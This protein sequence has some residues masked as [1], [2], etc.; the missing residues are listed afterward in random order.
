MPEPYS[1][2]STDGIILY[3]ICKYISEN[4]CAD[5]HPNTITII[6][7]MISFAIIYYIYCN[8]FDISTNMKYVLI[9]LFILR[10]FLDALDGTVARMY[11]KESE[12]GSML[13]TYSDICFYVCLIAII[14]TVSQLFSM[15]L[16]AVMLIYYLNIN[17]YITMILHDNTLLV[18]PCIGIL[19]LNTI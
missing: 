11:N 13:D 16:L 12:F 6:N 15:T 2:Y 5:I 17:T 19:M 3:P 10:A 1:I 8:N 18:M 14:F 4:F 7:S 9:M